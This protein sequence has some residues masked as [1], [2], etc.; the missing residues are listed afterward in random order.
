MVVDKGSYT[1]RLVASDG[2]DNI[3]DNTAPTHTS[4]A[5]KALT[6]SEWITEETVSGAAGP[7]AGADQ[8]HPAISGTTVVWQDMRDGNWDIYKRVLPGGAEEAVATGTA[9]QE[10]PDIDDVIVVW[11][12]F[13]GGS[14]D[15][16]GYDLSKP[17]ETALFPIATGTGDETNP[18]VSGTW[19]VWQDNSA[20]NWDIY[21]MNT[22]TSD[23][24]VRITSHERDQINP[25]IDGDTVVWEDLR[26]GA[27][28][29]YRYFLAAAAEERVTYNVDGQTLPAVSGDTLVWADERGGEKD[30]YWYTPARGVSKATYGA[31][32]DT[33]ASVFGNL[34]VYTDYGAGPDDP[35]LSFLDLLSGVGGTLVSAPARQEAADVGNG[36]VVWQDSRS[37]V[38]Q[39]YWAEVV[40]TPLPV[41][42]KIRPGFNLIAVGERL[43]T[44]YA[45]AQELISGGLG[46]ASMERVMAYNYLHNTYTEVPGAAADFPLV[47]GMGLV[48]YASG[49]GTV[50]VANP[51]EELP[52]G[53][54]LVQGSNTIGILSVS[55]GYSAHDLIDSVGIGN[56]QS[57]RRFDNWT[58]SWE[59]VSVRS[60]AG[61]FEKVGHNFTIKS[62][63]GLIITM[64]K[65]VGGWRP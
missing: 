2:L 65:S 9:D 17:Q 32:D 40:V 12:E 25:V 15:V 54:S 36:Y 50:E 58:G 16:Y 7:G 51:G 62:G 8:K 18:A 10:R 27:G 49:E 28:E 6:V 34:L 1:V 43:A 26:H 47:T 41:T 31:S 24:A 56:I 60:V 37:G 44:K 13:R 42:L 53:Y 35:N 22:A 3:F 30:I 59:T 63:E 19:V 29:I 61:G 23:P 11:Q 38:F 57:V 14:W 39:V 48:V 55:P 4:T 52:A 20:G 46:E 33:E 5:T 64:K 21:A 45:T